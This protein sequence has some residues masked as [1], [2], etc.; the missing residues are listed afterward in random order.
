MKSFRYQKIF[1]AAIIALTAFACT[2]TKYDS[3][4]DLPRQFKPG[5]ISI[6]AGQTEARLTWSP[7]LFT[8]GKNVTYTVEVS[9][10]STFQTGIVLSTVTD[11]SML[12]VTDS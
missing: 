5:D 9:T 11:T 12:V 3:N 10:D 7:S 6:N 1:L 4:F 8:A 2:K